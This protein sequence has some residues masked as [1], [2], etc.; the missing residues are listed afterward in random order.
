MT[1]HSYEIEI[2]SLLGSKEKADELVNKMRQ[3]D[4]NLKILGS[5]KQLN[6]Y[7][8][9]GNLKSLFDKVQSFLDD[10]SKKRLK[11]L[12]VRAKDFSVRTREAD[13]KVILVVKATVDDTTS[14]NGTARLEWEASPSSLLLSKEEY[15]PR[16]AREVV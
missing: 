2:T 1:R 3:Q 8:V 11:D 5:Y 12:S 14:N 10:E 13:G 7:F 9:G 16:G 4:P 15:P 6:H